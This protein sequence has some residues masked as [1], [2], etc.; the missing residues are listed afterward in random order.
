[1]FLVE[2]LQVSLWFEKYSSVQQPSQ[3]SKKLTTFHEMHC[4]A[5]CT[6]CALNNVSEPPDWRK[7]LGSAQ[8]FSSCLDSVYDEWQWTPFCIASM[9]DQL[10]QKQD[11]QKRYEGQY[12][13]GEEAVSCLWYFSLCPQ[14]HR[15]SDLTGMHSFWQ[16][17]HCQ[18]G[19]SKFSK[20]LVLCPGINSISAFPTGELSSRSPLSKNQEGT[21]LETNSKAFGIETFCCFEI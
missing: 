13:K 15:D 5:T 16:D 18:L 3:N 9:Y 17:L 7:L 10:C 1:M 8:N 19:T 6:V 12:L 11:F 21:H 2:V 14:M 4:I 20:P